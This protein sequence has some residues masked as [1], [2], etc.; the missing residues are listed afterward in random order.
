MCFL[1]CNK[2]RSQ[3]LP[4][5]LSLS[6]II[7]IFN[8]DAAKEES[9]SLLWLLSINPSNLSL[10]LTYGHSSCASVCPYIIHPS[11]CA[12]LFT[13]I[14]A[15]NPLE[16]VLALWHLGL[17][18]WVSFM[19]FSPCQ[20]KRAREKVI[21]YHQDVWKKKTEPWQARERNEECEFR[22]P[23]MKVHYKASLFGVGLLASSLSL[24][25]GAPPRQ[26]SMLASSP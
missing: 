18:G 4:S 1:L 17:W 19:L 16:G 3:L 9:S 12:F 21:N 23:M 22:G 6:I 24:A 11:I 13:H 25:L 10:S 5:L 26:G 20:C 14:P 2:K 7:I 15:K 8:G